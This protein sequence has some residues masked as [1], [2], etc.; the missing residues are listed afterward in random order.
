M[1]AS[2]A[3]RPKAA[4]APSAS[5]ERPTS[6]SS[7]ATRS[8]GCETPASGRDFARVP[9]GAP[10]P[11]RAALPT[12]PTIGRTDD[13]LEREADRLADQVMGAPDGGAS[14]VRPLAS[15]GDG[16]VIR[17][18]PASGGD[19]GP[20]R[21]LLSGPGQGLD[22]PTRAFFEP[23]FG[24]NLSQV[25]VHA[26][27]RAARAAT[28]IGA[29]AF[30]AGSH[31]GFAA[32]QYAPASPSGRRL[33]AHELAHV[34]QSANAPGAQAVVR[35]TPADPV[36]Y[37]STAA[38]FGPPAASD[39]LAS[40]KADISAKQAKTPDP[41]LGPTV[42]VKGVTAGAPEELYVWNVLR[43]R[44]DRA[45]WG[46]AIQ[47]VTAI[48]PKPPDPPGGAAPVGQITITLD[49]KGNATAELIDRGPVAVPAAYPDKDKAV[50]ALKTDFG[51][52]SVDD[53]TAAWTP[54]ELNKVYA[55]L[56][57]LPPA[58]RKVLTGAALVRDS[59]LTDP[60]G[61]PRDAAFRHASTATPGS[62]GTPSVASRDESLHV[63]NAAFFSDA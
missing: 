54:G 15:R 46:T 62:A 14:A 48:G 30:A 17:R 20:T 8:L 55:A 44:G 39:T 22:A 63:A 42:N 4:A 37:D 36:M 21:D 56:S 25:R 1:F 32:N 19:A 10:P 41:D 34:A 3:A 60:A 59:T 57:L 40:V 61:K 29:K 6:V 52:V 24:L 51:F 16:D 11:A 2:R 23:R 47:V 45:K 7:P 38:T 13:P 53:G 31:I 27:G 26:D 12:T 5:G 49:S 43:L 58:D 9:P 28:T 50:T 18:T 35:R 33:L